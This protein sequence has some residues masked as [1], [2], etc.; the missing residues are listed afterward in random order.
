[1]KN[2]PWRAALAAPLS[3][4]CLFQPPDTATN[5]NLRAS[6]SSADKLFLVLLRRLQPSA[7]I[8]HA[9]FSHNPRLPRVHRRLRPVGQVQLAQDI[10]D[11][12]L[13]GLLAYDERGRDLFV[14]LAGG[15][16]PQHV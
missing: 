12:A 14:A 9:L 7:L 10:R 15:H 5:K 3:T 11:M 1:M 16:Q 6:A 8:L 2:R 13:D 4:F